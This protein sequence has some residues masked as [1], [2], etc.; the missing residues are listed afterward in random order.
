MISQKIP[1]KQLSQRQAE[2]VSE[3]RAAILTILASSGKKPGAI[4]HV[5]SL[6]QDLADHYH[7]PVKKIIELGNQLVWAALALLQLQ[8]WI[9]IDPS[10]PRI[11]VIRE[12][13]L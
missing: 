9:K 10:R 7:A 1:E 5:T 4:V 11:R 6:Y 3:I 8:G 13:K 2:V 12:I